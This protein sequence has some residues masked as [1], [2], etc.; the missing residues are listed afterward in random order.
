MRA[1]PTVREITVWATPD[2]PT[3]LSMPGGRPPEFAICRLVKVR[4]GV[5][6][7]EPL[8]LDLWLKMKPDFCHSLGIE[9]SDDT[10]KRLGR[11][12]FVSMRHVAPQVILINVQS[13][14]KHLEESKDSRFW[15]R[16]RRLQYLQACDDLQQL[17]KRKHF[18]S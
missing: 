8:T 13:L 15:T 16:E 18:N 5:F 12:G 1:A 7:L 11:A 17:K 6:H 14:L 9:L 2:A 3:R 10:L 4:E